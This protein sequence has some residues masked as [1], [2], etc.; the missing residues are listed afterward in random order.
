MKYNNKNEM[1]EQAVLLYLKGKTYIDIAEIIGCS[2]NYVSNLIKN[3]ERVVKKQN[4]KVLKIHN[5]TPT[6]KKSLT[7]GINVLNKIGISRNN[8]I[9]EY[10]ELLIDESNK[11]ILIKKKDI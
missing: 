10:V 2:R 6:T 1:K 9:E 5:S 8:D 3:D 4:L 7:I 11:Q